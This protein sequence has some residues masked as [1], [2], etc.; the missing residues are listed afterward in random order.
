MK[1]KLLDRDELLDVYDACFRLLSPRVGSGKYT[2]VHF[3]RSHGCDCFK[4]AIDYWKDDE[5]LLRSVIRCLIPLAQ[6]PKISD[7]LRKCGIRTYMENVLDGNKLDDIIQRDANDALSAVNKA[8]TRLAMAHIEE[9]TTTQTPG[10]I[11]RAMVEHPR[12]RDVHEA[13]LDALWAMT[14]N[15]SKIGE[16]IAHDGH[17]VITDTIKRFPTHA[18]IQTKGFGTVAG[19]GKNL[20]ACSLLGKEETI[21]LAVQAYNK[22]ENNF[23]VQQQVLWAL[24]TLAQLCKFAL[25]ETHSS[26]GLPCS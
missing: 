14:K 5:V 9:G 16:I 26:N 17:I 21:K 11:I 24:D 15:D 7:E 4:A 22:F 25:Q 10:L 3:F 6:N 19:L 1:E 2:Q 8:G 23:L 18:S 12:K 13:A 20:T